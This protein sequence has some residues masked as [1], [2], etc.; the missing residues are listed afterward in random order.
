MECV[1]QRRVAEVHAEPSL[2][3][4]HVH[5]AGWRRRLGGRRAL[6]WNKSGDGQDGHP[7]RN[8]EASH[9]EAPWEGC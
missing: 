7:E 3:H 9:G 2:A 4:G 8:D 6:G 1:G 5:R